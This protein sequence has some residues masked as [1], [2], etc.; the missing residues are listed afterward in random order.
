MFD[1]AQGIL[2]F[3]LIG[4]E[5]FLDVWAWHGGSGVCVRREGER[6]N[7]STRKQ[8]PSWPGV[9]GIALSLVPE[10]SIL[11]LRHRKSLRDR[12][13]HKLS[14]ATNKARQLRIESTT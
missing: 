7:Y 3:L 4:A 12:N 5:E 6:R 10:P 1:D 2:I 13:W 8:F 11:C 9:F 14:P